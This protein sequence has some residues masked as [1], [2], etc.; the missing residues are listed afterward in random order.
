MMPKASCRPVF[1]TRNRVKLVDWINHRITS[2]HFLKCPLEELI[3]L[4]LT[5]YSN[6]YQREE[7]M[8]DLGAVLAT[9]NQE[10]DKLNRAIDALTGVAGSSGG[11]GRRKLSAAAR[12]RI[13][14]A[15]RKRWAKFKRKRVER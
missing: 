7:T 14:A 9:L 11:S 6:P 12:E 10:R 13:A 15:Q 3:F 4:S 2:A 5:G 8:T 1:V